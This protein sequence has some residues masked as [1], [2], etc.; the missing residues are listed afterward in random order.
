MAVGTRLQ[1]GFI[2]FHNGSGSGHEPALLLGAQ[3]LQFQFFHDRQGDLVLNCK[4]VF[5]RPASKDVSL[6]PGCA[7]LPAPPTLWYPVLNPAV[8]TVRKRLE[9]RKVATLDQ[10]YFRAV[11]P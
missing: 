8:I 11:G 10:R 9:E 2:G 6:T 5:Q 3:Q 1:V 7:S 4:D